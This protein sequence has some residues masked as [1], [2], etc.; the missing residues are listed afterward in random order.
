M[1][2]PHSRPTLGIEEKD[3]LSKVIDSL[4]VAE[5]PLVEKF[6]TKLS[7]YIGLLGGVA[8]NSG[9]TALHLAFLVLGIG[10]GDEV[11]VPTYVDPSLKYCSDYLSANCVLV[12]ID[13]D[14]FNISIDSVKAKITQRTKA[15]VVP[16]M[17]G[18]PAQVIKFKELGIPI[19]EDC[20]FLDWS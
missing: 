17:F 16:H 18:F 15:I 5:G 10:Q 9:T 13:R 4:Q 6:E 20:A 1:V 7:N 11:I 2:I 12:D 8:T 19:I 14:D 3:A